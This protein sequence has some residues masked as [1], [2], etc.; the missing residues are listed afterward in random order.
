MDIIRILDGNYAQGATRVTVQ[1]NS[2]LNSFFRL[3]ENIQKAYKGP[4][5]GNST[6]LE[7]RVSPAFGLRAVRAL[8]SGLA[9]FRVRCVGAEFWGYPK[10]PSTNRAGS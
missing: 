9:V 1:G 3:P 4:G 10:G 6:G 8:G 5:Q 7:F 2:F